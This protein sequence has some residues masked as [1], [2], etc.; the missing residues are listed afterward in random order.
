MR[1]SSATWTTQM[2]LLPSMS[3][4]MKTSRC[5]VLTC[6]L[7]K[8]SMLMLR[9]WKEMKSSRP[10]AVA[11]EDEA[12]EGAAGEVVT[13]IANQV[14]GGIENVVDQA[15]VEEAIDQGSPA[16]ISE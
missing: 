16:G 3:L 10:K 1:T 14:G 5:S 13:D 4:E 11:K 8:V 12:E 6:S 15:D 7:C 9:I 2:G